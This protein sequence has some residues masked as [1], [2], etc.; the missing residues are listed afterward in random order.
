MSAAFTMKSLR[1][2]S[3]NGYFRYRNRP[4]TGFVFLYS[5]ENLFM[6]Y[7]APP[8]ANPA[9]VGGGGALRYLGIT[10]TEIS[11]QIAYR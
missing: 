7:V 8:C 1:V 6:K 3:N 4:W 9:P 10:C 11:L 2:I 5:A